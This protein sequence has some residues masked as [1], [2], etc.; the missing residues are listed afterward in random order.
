[1]KFTNRIFV[2]AFLCLARLLLEVDAG[3]TP[4]AC[5]L[6]M[7]HEQC[8]SEEIV[9]NQHAVEDMR[10]VVAVGDVHGSYVGL[11]EVLYQANI[12]KSRDSCIWKSQGD[13]A[14]DGVVLVQVGDLT[15]RGPGAL[16]SLECLRALQN[17]AEAH[18]SKV[19]RLLGSKYYYQQ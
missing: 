19:V 15:D 18:H 13:G 11:L 16:E 10:R 12:T 6:K 3:E 17:G 8:T 9:Q 4:L 5:E 14:N 7:K 2:F 1:M